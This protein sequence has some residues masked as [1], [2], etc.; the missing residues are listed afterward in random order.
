MFLL[1][2]SGV[3]FLLHYDGSYLK[4]VD[5]L[6]KVALK[7]LLLAFICLHI[8]Q[9]VSVYR[10][11]YS[12]PPLDIKRKKALEEAVKLTYFQQF[13]ARVLPLRLGEVA[14]V[15]MIKK[16]LKVNIAGNLAAYSLI[17]I[18][19]LRIIVG[20]FVLTAVMNRSL[21]NLETYLEH[22]IAY[23]I[24]GVICSAIVFPL[25]YM[26][27]SVELLK[28]LNLKLSNKNKALYKI[29]LFVEDIYASYKKSIESTSY[30]VHGFL[31]FLN[32]ALAYALF[33]FVYMSLN[34]YLPPSVVILFTSALI[35]LTI[36]P[37]QS[38]GGLGIGEAGLSGLLVLYGF[39][40]VDAIA[41]GFSVGIIHTTL[42]IALLA[43]FCIYKI[44]KR[45]YLSA[46]I[47]KSH[48]KM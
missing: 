8:L 26:R 29:Y 46:L 13:L 2:T 42:S 18:C 30:F 38:I 37:L 41:T 22:S 48:W 32:W 19:D 10:L 15:F 43:S 14:Y 45:I 40:S 12:L 24:C 35:L 17:R 3:L 20:S 34:L 16:L 39:Q 1:A 33:G 31:S 23:F 25:F 5:Q 11:L 36:L 21:F 6:E 4:L 28:F 7:P 9:F 27:L 44:L 47:H